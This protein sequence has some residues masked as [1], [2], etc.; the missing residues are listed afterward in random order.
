MGCSIIQILRGR[1][2]LT[3][4]FQPGISEEQGL[5]YGNSLVVVKALIQKIERGIK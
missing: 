1:S 4:K 5:F 3:M 2:Y